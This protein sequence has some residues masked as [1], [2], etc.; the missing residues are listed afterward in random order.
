MFGA[1]SFG[2]RLI[3]LVAA[4]ALGGLAVHY[5]WFTGEAIGRFARELGGRGDAL[6]PSSNQRNR[7]IT[8]QYERFRPRAEVV[9]IGDSHT[10]HGVWEDMFPEIRVANRGV[11]FDRTTDVL[12]RLDHIVALGPA[13]AFIML[14]TNDVF[15]KRA[16]QE[17]LADYRRIVEGVQSAGAKVHIVSTLECSRSVCAESLDRIRDLNRALQAYAASAGLTF[18]DL[19]PQLSEAAGGLRAEYTYDGIHLLGAGYE[20]WRDTL[21]PYLSGRPQA[22]GRAQGK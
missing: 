4:F 6:A 18:V 1:N 21:T 3:A 5:R 11:G 7:N 12:A 15:Q 20:L 9:M 8:S 17:I 16:L 2:S 22:K 10:Q 19:N 14:G 13:Q